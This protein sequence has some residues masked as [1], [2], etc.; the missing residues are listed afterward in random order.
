[1]ADICWDPNNKELMRDFA[2]KDRLRSRQRAKQ[3]SSPNRH[4][5]GITPMTD[6]TAAPANA[7]PTGEPPIAT[8]YT[9]PIDWILD[10]TR[11]CQ[12]W[13]NGTRRQ[14]KLMLGREADGGQEDGIP[15]E[16][17]A[18]ALDRLAAGLIEPRPCRDGLMLSWTAA[19]LATDGEL[20]PADWFHLARAARDWRRARTLATP[21]P[22]P[23]HGFAG[24]EDALDPFAARVV[25]LALVN[26]LDFLGLV[27]ARAGLAHVGS[28]LEVGQAIKALVADP[29]DRLD[30]LDHFGVE[31]PLFTKGILTPTSEMTCTSD[32]RRC[33]LV[34]AP[35]FLAECLGQRLAKL[36]EI[37]GVEV[38]HPTTTMEEVVL[39]PEIAAE[40]AAIDLPGTIARGAGG[41]PFAVL[42]HGPSGT[43]KT[44]LA[45]ALA[46][47]AGRPLLLYTGTD[48]PS[49]DHAGNLIALLRRA[50]HD[51][52]I[53]F[54]DEVDHLAAVGSRAS[55][56]LLTG[57]E[58]HPA[59]VIMATNRPLALDPAL[60]RRLPVKLHL[61]IP[62]REERAAIIRLEMKRHGLRLDD[63]AE[64][65]RIDALARIYRIS[66]GWWRNV[67]RLAGVRAGIARRTPGTLAAEDLVAAARREACSLAGDRAN[68]HWRDTLRPFGSGVI[69]GGRL[70]EAQEFA[71]RLAQARSV[72]AEGHPM[73][74]VVILTGPEP[75]LAQEI[76]E[77]LAHALDL[78]LA[79]MPA[80]AGDEEDGDGKGRGRRK[81]G[82]STGPVVDHFLA[83]D[84]QAG[85]TAVSF[86]TLEGG[87]DRWEHLLAGI[88]S[89]RHLVVVH[90]PDG[91]PSPTL[92]AA[93]AAVLPWAQLDPDI[94]AAAWARLGGSGAA[95]VARTM[96][97]LHAARM[98][99]MLGTGTMTGSDVALP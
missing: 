84:R 94:L 37:I 81:G 91:S 57:L 74:A 25:A 13:I 82:A 54:L 27:L 63:P 41:R 65:P 36:T 50:S 60:D 75:I 1:M 68:L 53:L 97:D 47:A 19:T 33:D 6:A 61:D 70:R 78:P 96:A 93:A 9:R 55:R 14:R 64:E 22:Y 46:H 34:L 4:P 59:I 90:H 92:R 5:R 88:P 49:E 43:G 38:V 72:G 8:A 66:G 87:N 42:L 80:I 45:Q 18:A 30:A 26:H 31:S 12:A 21:Q 85:E 24:L 15:V 95:P 51:R 39:A 76:A 20:D 99:Q 29:L 16:L 69:V 62:R 17:D 7:I 56:A 2:I 32:L 35:A 89:T 40:I 11:E 3:A 23:A 83:R 28:R 79:E 86:L 98:R 48:D 77:G 67:V 44:L 71:A 73:G 10:L 52:A 58:Q